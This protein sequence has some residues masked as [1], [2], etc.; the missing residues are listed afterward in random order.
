MRTHGRTQEEI[1]QETG[2]QLLIIRN[3]THMMGVILHHM[4]DDMIGK[5]NNKAQMWN[6]HWD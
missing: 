5:N 2:K 3:V 4:F 6:E 1:K